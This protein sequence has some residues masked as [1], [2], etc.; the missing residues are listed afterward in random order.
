MTETVSVSGN[1][2]GCGERVSWPD[3]AT[4]ETLLIC[5][6]CGADLGTYGD[7]KNKAVETVKRRLVDIM[8]DTFKR[9]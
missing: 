8:K 7:F 2:G 6:N 4:E 1:C 3:D 9:R 5:K